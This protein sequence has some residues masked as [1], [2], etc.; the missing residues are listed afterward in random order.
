MTLL[1]AIGALIVVLGVLIFIHEAGH[2]VAAKAAGIH[3]H[4]F[5]LGLGSP[6][7]WLTF[8]RGETEYS[9]SWLPLGGYVKMATR[10][11]EATSS[12]LEGTSTNVGVPPE[13]YF[14]AKPVWV[15]MVVILAGVAMNAVFAWAAFTY[16]VAKNGIAVNPVT[17]V[18]WVID[19]LVPPEAESLTQLEPGDRIVAVAGSPVESWNDV[20]R[21]IRSAPGDSVVIEVAGRDPLIL[22]IHHDALEARIRAA[23]AVQPWQPSV[24]GEVLPDKPASAIGLEEGDTI[25]SLAGT[26]VSQWG[27]LVDIIEQ[28]ANT[29]IEIVIGRAGRRIRTHVTPVPEEVTDPDGTTRVVGKMGFRFDPAVEIIEQPLGA[30]IMAGFNETL[31]QSTLIV[32]TVRGMFSGRVSRRE[33]GGPILIGQLAGEAAQLGLDQFVFFMGIISINL[34]IL[35]LLPIPILDGGQFLFLLAEGVMR[36]P[37]SLRLRERLTAVGLFLLISLM[38]LVFWND[39]TRVLTSVTGG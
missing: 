34:A 25:V 14:E 35:N 21:L 4:R 18:G 5:S 19:S 32:R 26:E 11:E 10:E 33:V 13:G 23:V 27:E 37:L 28:N 29:E 2:F 6:I 8:K 9:V 20:V 31:N 17:T 30:A 39:I 38:G 16:I 12:A 36:R 22:P 24:V 1:Y 7:R 3:V 15:R